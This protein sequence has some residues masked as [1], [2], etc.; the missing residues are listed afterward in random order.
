MFAEPSRPK[1]QPRDG[2]V[3]A[4]E[5]RGLLLLAEPS[6]AQPDRYFWKALRDGQVVFPHLMHPSLEPVPLEVAQSLAKNAAK[7]IAR[8]DLRA[9]E[10]L[11]A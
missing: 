3:W 5:S 6:H 10:G 1:W 9:W 8:D 7:C 2:G 4:L 11:A